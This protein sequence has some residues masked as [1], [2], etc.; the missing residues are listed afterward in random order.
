M[1]SE[2]AGPTNR[3][4]RSALK[5]IGILVSGAVAKS[6]LPT[7]AKAESLPRPAGLDRLA[8][9]RPSEQMQWFADKLGPRGSLWP[10][11]RAGDFTDTEIRNVLG[12]MAGIANALNAPESNDP[13]LEGMRQ[14]IRALADTPHLYTVSERVNGRW[15][16]YGN[17]QVVNYKGRPYIKS[18]AHVIDGIAAQHTSLVDHFRTPSLRNGHR[19]DVL[20]APLRSVPGGGAQSNRPVEVPEDFNPQEC[21]GQV[22]VIIGY[23]DDGGLLIHSGIVLPTPPAMVSRLRAHWAISTPTEQ[24]QLDVIMRQGEGGLMLMPAFFGEAQ[25]NTQLIRASGRSGSLRRV[26]SPRHRMFVPA[27]NFASGLRGVT[28]GMYRGWVDSMTHVSRGLEE[29]H[30]V[31]MSAHEGAPRMV[32]LAPKLNFGPGV[33]EI[34]PGIYLRSVRNRNAAGGGIAARR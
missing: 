20:F 3:A 25:F 11:L 14:E 13:R 26:Y 2:E 19:P 12:A 8:A 28:N 31:M 17:A 27:S 7:T 4:R 9:M 16:D 6:L 33:Y 30:Q 34:V 10:M 24:R 21:H 23:K 29:M 32:D 5:K 18:S 22:N 1:N 15:H